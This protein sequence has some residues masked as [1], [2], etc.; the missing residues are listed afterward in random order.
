MVFGK[1]PYVYKNLMNPDDFELAMQIKV[2]KA[3][4]TA[5]SN[6]HIF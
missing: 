5:L 6:S 2:G 4:F 3:Q 1:P